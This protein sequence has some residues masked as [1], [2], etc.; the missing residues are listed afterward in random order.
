MNGPLTVIFYLPSLKYKY[1]KNKCI[2]GVFYP[3][4]SNSTTVWRRLINK[5]DFEF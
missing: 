3:K 4:T 1:S 5:S 2:Y